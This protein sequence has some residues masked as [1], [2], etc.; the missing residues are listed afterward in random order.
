MIRFTNPPL[1]RRAA[2][3]SLGVMT[4]VPV[5]M[6]ADYPLTDGEMQ[7]FVLLKQRVPAPETVFLDAT[8]REVRLADFRG[9]VLL[10]N[11]W[12]TWCAPCIDELPSLA[13][14]ADAFEGRP[15]RLMAVSQDRDG[16]RVVEP[17]VRERLGL[18]TL[19]IFY[20]PKLRLGRAF[21]T[22][23]LP[24][25]YLIDRMGRIIGSLEGDAEWDGPDAKALIRHALK[26]E[27]PKRDVVQET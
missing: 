13:R 2:L 6:A 15:F 19:R 27:T 25:T 21:G 12:A 16:R 8:E 3:A 1:T 9:E 20:D 18:P 22:R 4:T 11:F 14:L 23:A 5:V 24:S 17:V 10:V 7:G 26:E